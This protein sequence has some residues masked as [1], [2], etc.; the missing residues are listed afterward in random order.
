MAASRCRARTF[1]CNVEDVLAELSDPGVTRGDM[2]PLLKYGDDT[3]DMMLAG[4]SKLFPV[5]D[6]EAML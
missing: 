4:G 2:F 1:S 3:L 6:F 5:E